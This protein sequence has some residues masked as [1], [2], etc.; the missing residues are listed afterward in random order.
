MAV[1]Q[2]SLEARAEMIVRE[3]GPSYEFV[4]AKER[5]KGYA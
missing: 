1:V 3:S 4:E 5:I 2:L